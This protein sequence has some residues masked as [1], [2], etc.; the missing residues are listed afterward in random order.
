MVGFFCDS[1][2]GRFRPQIRIRRNSKPNCVTKATTHSFSG[3]GKRHLSMCQ[4]ESGESLLLHT[5]KSNS[6]HPQGHHS[7]RIAFHITRNFV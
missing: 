3:A 4:F 1:L 2:A 6:I 5:E 7:S